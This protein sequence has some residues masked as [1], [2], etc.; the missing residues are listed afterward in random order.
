M[1]CERVIRIDAV[2]SFIE[3]DR[4]FVAS[5]SLE[6]RRGV[7]ASVQFATGSGKV[8][9]SIVELAQTAECQAE[10]VQDAFVFGSQFDGAFQPVDSSAVVPL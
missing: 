1:D 8:L 4:F 10:V 2:R 9:V 5:Q 7:D 6:H 3:L